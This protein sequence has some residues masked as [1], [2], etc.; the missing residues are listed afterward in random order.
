MKTKKVSWVNQFQ[1][2]SSPASRPFVDFYG[3]RYCDTV[4]KIIAVGLESRQGGGG[5]R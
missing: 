5:Q 2:W 3:L 1:A 4:K